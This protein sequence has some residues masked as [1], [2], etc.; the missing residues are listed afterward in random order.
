MAKPGGLTAAFLPNR[1]VSRPVMLGLTLA[2]A[3]LAL[4]FWVL[5]P[6]QTLP[7]PIEVWKAL[8]SL[9]WNMASGRGRR[10]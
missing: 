9:W 4:L 1:A 8:G 10:C 3:G 6:W 2:W 5:S 7:G